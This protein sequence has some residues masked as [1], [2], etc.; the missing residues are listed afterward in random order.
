MEIWLNNFSL[1]HYV[2]EQCELIIRDLFIGC[3]WEMVGLQG[4]A[5]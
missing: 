1:Y 2:E 4:K 5:L 3:T